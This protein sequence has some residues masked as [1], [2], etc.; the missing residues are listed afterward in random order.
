[1]I[2]VTDFKK[3]YDNVQAVRGLTF[4]VGP[5]QVWGLVGH[6]GAGKTTTMRAVA[7]LLPPSAGDDRDLGH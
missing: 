5:S 4:E 3:A 2:H 6:N 1:M 7:G